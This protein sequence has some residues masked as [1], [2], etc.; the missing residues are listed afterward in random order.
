MKG[1]I[2]H[3]QVGFILEMQEWLNICKSV[4][5]I[6]HVNKTKDKDHMIIS[7]NAEKSFSKIK[8]LF[9][10]GSAHTHPAFWTESSPSSNTQQHIHGEPGPEPGANPL[11]DNRR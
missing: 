6:H 4:I 10:D 11:I 8:H 5:V 1:T 7:I 9:A 2:H 3:N